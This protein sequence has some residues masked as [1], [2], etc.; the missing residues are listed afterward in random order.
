LNFQRVDFLLHPRGNVR[1]SNGI[2]DNPAKAT[3]L[4]FR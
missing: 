2:G 3:T 1:S 4:N